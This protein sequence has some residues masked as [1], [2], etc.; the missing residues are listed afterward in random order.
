[1]SPLQ[2][3]VGFFLAG[4]VL[5]GAGAGSFIG[6]RIGLQEGLA[7]DISAREILGSEVSALHTITGQ[8]QVSLQAAEASINSLTRKIDDQQRAH[9]YENRELELYRRIESGGLDKGIHVN[10]IELIDSINGPLLRVTLLQVG[11]RNDVQGMLG[12]AFI[13]AELPGA[14]DDRVILAGDAD[15]SALE[16]D[17]RF[18]SRISVDLPDSL[19]AGDDSGEPFAW[20][21]GLDMVEVDITPRDS[22]RRPKRVTV[23]ADRLKVGSAE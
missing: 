2:S 15:D 18:M 14:A 20:L 3:V 22:R 12:V 23:P 8:Q 11:A 5:L 6:Y 4:G 21:A 17:F 1:M 16:F 9:E 7:A 19:P 10:E 13:G